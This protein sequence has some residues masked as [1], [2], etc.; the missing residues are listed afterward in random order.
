MVTGDPKSL[1]SRPQCLTDSRG[2]SWAPGR[3]AAGIGGAGRGLMRLADK[4]SPL[5][6]GARDQARYI[7]KNANFIYLPVRFPPRGRRNRLKSTRH[8]WAGLILALA[9]L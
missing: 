7:I 2:L 8:L 1:M 5:P 9:E 6:R 3:R 4:H